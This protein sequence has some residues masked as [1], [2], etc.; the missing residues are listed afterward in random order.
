RLHPFKN[1]IP[2][3]ELLGKVLGREKQANEYIAFYKSHYNKIEQRLK[4]KNLPRPKVYMEMIRGE[5][6]V[7]SPGKGNLGEF[8]DFV[9]AHNIGAD[10][11]PGEVGTLNMEYVIRQ[12]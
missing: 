8:I 11:L 7:G 1:T 9:G 6:L 2:S 4:G 10:I 3:M 12:Q 5:N